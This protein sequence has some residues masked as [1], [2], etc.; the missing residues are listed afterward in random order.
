MKTLI[1]LHGFRSS[2]QSQKARLLDEALRA[3][4]SDWEYITP[5]LSFDPGLAIAQIES[6]ISRC[7]PADLTL[8]GSS[9]GGFYAEICAEK[10]G[11]R[12]ALLNPSLAPF[13]TLVSHLGMQ[14]PLTGT[15]DSF[16]FTEDHL[17][18]LRRMDVQRISSPE[19]YLVI[20]EMGDELLDHRRTLEKFVGATTIAVDGGNHDLLSFPSHICALLRHAGL[21][22]LA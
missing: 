12:A 19:K 15:G 6:I 17:A 16:E 8:V 9:L 3:L 11:C 4:N 13:E 10:I 7:A 20:V 1:Y 21:T 18:L 2:S 22:N 5:D 14:T